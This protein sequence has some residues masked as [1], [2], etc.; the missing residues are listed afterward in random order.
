MLQ[1]DAGYACNFLNTVLE[2]HRPDNKTLSKEP[3]VDRKGSTV[4]E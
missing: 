4:M 2:Y 1:T 3:K